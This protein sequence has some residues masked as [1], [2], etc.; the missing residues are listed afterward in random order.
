MSLDFVGTR[1]TS[2]RRHPPCVPLGRLLAAATVAV[3]LTGALT[4]GSR[5]DRAEADVGGITW[6]DE[7]NGAAG[8]GVDGAKWG[9]DTGGGGFGN[10]ELEYYT[11]VHPQR[12]DG[13]AG[14][15]GDHRAPGEPG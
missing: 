5:A 12:R 10:N 7:F 3:T 6:S 2:P 15:P 1:T 14:P 4:V 8:T 9:F 11:T 13:R